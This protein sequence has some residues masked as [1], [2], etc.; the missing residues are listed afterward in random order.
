LSLPRS[1]HEW[2]VEAL[3]LAPDDHVLEVGCG[4]GVAVS[5]VCERL[6]AGTITAIDR[7][8]KMVEAARRRNAEYAA[9]GRATIEVAALEEAAFG[10]KRFDKVFAFH[11][12]DFWRRP[13]EMLPPVRRALAARGTLTLFDQPLSQPDT[14]AVQ[15][16]GARPSLP[17]FPSRTSPLEGVDTRSA[18][19][20]SFR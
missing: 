9:L 11:V 16:F 5:L 4:H 7:S 2:A 20:G 15:R 19:R 6:D 10:G 14:A 17:S 1:R 18:A 12:A 3:R 13:F 8:P